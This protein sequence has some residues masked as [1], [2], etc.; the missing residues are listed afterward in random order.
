VGRF[1]HPTL[2]QLLIAYLVYVR[3]IEVSMALT[4]AET[5]QERALAY[6]G[7]YWLF[8]RNGKPM[9]DDAICR[10]IA[11]GL[12]E[13]NLPLG[14]QQHR[15]GFAGILRD[16]AMDKEL[17]EYLMTEEQEGHSRERGFNSYAVRVDIVAVLREDKFFNG[18]TDDCL[19]SAFRLSGR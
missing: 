13:R 16:M 5:D 6:K 8:W 12:T 3:P 18:R 17:E 7:R 4:L 1:L 14:F 19:Y 2:A 11:L 10:D 15:H 9:S